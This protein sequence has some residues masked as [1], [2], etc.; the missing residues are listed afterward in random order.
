MVLPQMEIVRLSERSLRKAAEYEPDIVAKIGSPL[1]SELNEMTQQLLKQA[2][3]QYHVN[4]QEPNYFHGPTLTMALAYESELD[5]RVVW[6]ILKELLASGIE[7]YGS[8]ARPLIE[9]K[10]INERSLTTGT[11]ARYLRKD[12]EFGKKAR[13]RGFNV[14]MIAKDAF[15]VT[16]VA[17]KRLTIQSAREQ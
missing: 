8:P 16:K 17:T 15:D 6:P 9:Q 4:S 10:K 14:E 7:N 12:L 11:I 5:V 1:Y 2:E 13:G 3:F